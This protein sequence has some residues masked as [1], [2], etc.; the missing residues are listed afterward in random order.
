MAVV[1]FEK[2]PVGEGVGPLVTMTLNGWLA[3]NAG[4]V[5]LSGWPVMNAGNI[6]GDPPSLIDAVGEEELRLPNRGP[7]MLVFNPPGADIEDVRFVRMGTVPL[8]GEPIS[9]LAVEMIDV[10]SVLFERGEEGDVVMTCG[11]VTV[12]YESNG[13]AV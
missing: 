8:T 10:A 2:L 12:I 4:P 5:T 3:L 11:A 13:D 6:V 7:G 9:M 1:V